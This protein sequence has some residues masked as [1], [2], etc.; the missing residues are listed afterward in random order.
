MDMDSDMDLDSD[1]DM[2]SDTDMDI[3]MDIGM[4]SDKHMVFH[5][6]L[7][8]HTHSPSQHYSFVSENDGVVYTYSTWDIH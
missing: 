5:H 1:M 8:L 3:G 4:D 6:L 2:D 7:L